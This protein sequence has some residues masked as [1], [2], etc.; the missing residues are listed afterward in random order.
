MK[1]ILIRK[2]FQSLSGGFPEY[3]FLFDP[4]TERTETPQFEVKHSTY[5]K[6]W[7]VLFSQMLDSVSYS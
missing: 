6:V 3:G 5:K 7:C 1:L 2:N 4:F